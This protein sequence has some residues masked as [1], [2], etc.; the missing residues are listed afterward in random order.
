M[1][2]P[3]KSA[4]PIPFLKEGYALAQVLAPDEET[5]GRLTLDA[6]AV[7]AGTSRFALLAALL[8]DTHLPTPPSVPPSGPP[9][10]WETTSGFMTP[11][12]STSP[13]PAEVPSSLIADRLA[14][15]Q[16]GQEIL[17]RFA[18]LPAAERGV[19]YLGLVRGL[20]T[21]D[22]ATLFRVSPEHVAIFQEAAAQS[23][24]GDP[25]R[26]GDPELLASSMKPLLS[27]PGDTLRK[28]V[29][30][31]MTAAL[32]GSH[33]ELAR[34][35]PRGRLL[36]VLGILMLSVIAAL[37]VTRL[38]PRSSAGPPVQEAAD[39]LEAA[40]T[41]LPLERHQITSSDPLE[42]EAW[43]NQRIPWR[44]TVPTVESLPLA[45]AGL[46]RLVSGVRIPI[47]FY[48]SR[49]TDLSIGVMNYAILQASSDRLMLDRPT[50]DRLASG[51]TPVLRTI[52]GHS[53][54]AMRHRD[55]I[56]LAVSREID[57][58]LPSRITFGTE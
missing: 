37:A 43:M 2:K 17:G 32:K 57:V 10:R 35:A 19:A 49:E 41:Q 18:R 5:A 8:S 51:E 48:G 45:G 3:D 36:P 44:F 38:F 55:D 29:R 1:A 12:V 47:L 20:A 53:V 21:A 13:A 16:R 52:D 26:P 4:R 11:S 40:A 28:S 31:A 23:L 56:Y 7:T 34:P 30:A 24:F 15:E 46:T 14:A 58:A 54:L 22:L 9:V 27:P 42:I 33:S 6:Y 50:I 25:T 39:A